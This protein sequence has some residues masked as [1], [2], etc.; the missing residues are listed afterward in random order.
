VT[1]PHDVIA[2]IETTDPKALGEILISQVQKI[3]GIA[4]TLTDVVID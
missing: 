3:E 2:Y 4:G 1:G